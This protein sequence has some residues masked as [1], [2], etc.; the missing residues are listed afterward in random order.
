M[1]PSLYLQRLS[2]KHTAAGN[3]ESDS[4]GLMFLL[5]ANMTK[6]GM[7]GRTLLLMESAFR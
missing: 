7:K 2:P 1:E 3:G 5:W 6:H 4:R